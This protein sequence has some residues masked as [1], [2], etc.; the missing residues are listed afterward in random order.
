[1]VLSRSGIKSLKEVSRLF[2][3]YMNCCIYHLVWFLVENRC[4][5][6]SFH[7][8]F[9]VTCNV[10]GILM[11]QVLEIH[12]SARLTRFLLSWS[13]HSIGGDMIKRIISDCYKFCNKYRA[14]QSFH[15]FSCVMPICNFY[16]IFSFHPSYV[17]FI[18]LLCF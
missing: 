16:E 1:M 9:I 7:K 18:L 12:W 15:F 5:L 14:I 6:S 17:I 3:S 11:I 8:Y 4:I 2:V 10:S 13:L